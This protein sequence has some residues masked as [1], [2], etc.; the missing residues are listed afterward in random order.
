MTRGEN[1]QP[2]LSAPPWN[3]Y[4]ADHLARR[5][6]RG[7][8]EGLFSH[9]LLD[10][11]GKQRYRYEISFVPHGIDR[12][13]ASELIFAL[14]KDFNHAGYHHDPAALICDF[15]DA[16][17]EESSRGTGLLLELHS[18]PDR[19]NNA[20]ADDARPPDVQD[21]EGGPLPSLGLIPNWSVR[22]SRSG[23]CQ[24]SPNVDEPSVEI[25]SLRVRRLRLRGPNG[26]RWKQVIKNIR[27]VD[28]TKIIETRFDRLSWKGYSFGDVVAA[29][30]LA[31]AIST[32]GVGWDGR[33]TFEELITSPY[34]TYRR[35]RFARFWIE[36][37]ED[38]LH[39]LNAFTG[40]ESL[41][42]SA[43]FHFHLAGLPTPAVLTKAMQDLRSGSLTVEGAY[44]YLFPR[45]AS[46]EPGPAPWN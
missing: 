19:R 25:P 43:A 7:V 10:D 21:T 24:V 26:S 3:L 38:S 31:I 29:R 34:M 27:R 37:V 33:G 14:L 36:A 35:L 5:Q 45:Y 30:D 28:D 23:L 46:H 41:Y 16:L 8:R 4:Q 12:S 9:M 42:G 6:S 17:F 44:T 32:A 15:V 13:Q 11:L 18:L 40:S 1:L 39:F 22:T 2:R 20:T